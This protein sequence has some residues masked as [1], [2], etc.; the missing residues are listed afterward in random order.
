M[1]R[2]KIALVLALASAIML[3]A[4]CDTG[5]QPQ[6]IVP[7]PTLP[8]Q[9]TPSPDMKI[10]YLYSGG[11]AGARKELVIGPTGEATLTERGTVVGTFH[12]GIESVTELVRK[13]EAARIF[14]L[15]D[16]NEKADVV[17]ADDIY[18]TITYTQAGR[19]QTVTAAQVGGQGITPQAFLDLVAQLNELVTAFEGKGAPKP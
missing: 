12:M 11:I 14:D 15:Q 8:F 17:V 7:T 10:V 18:T 6:T 4:A 19:T 2:N 9:V 16:K 1:M 13:F 5:P 3:L